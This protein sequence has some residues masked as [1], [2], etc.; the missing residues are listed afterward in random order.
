MERGGVGVVLLA[1]VVGDLLE[2]LVE[3]ARRFREAFD[4]VLELSAAGSKCSVCFRA[5]AKLGVDDRQLGL[6]FSCFGVAL[7]LDFDRLV[8]GACA[9]VSF[10]LLPRGAPFSCFWAALRNDEGYPVR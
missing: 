10:D 4:L 9:D 1:E 5:G 3:G 6:E 2:G 8:E 7:R